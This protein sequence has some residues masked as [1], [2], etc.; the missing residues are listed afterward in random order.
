MYFILIYLTTPLSMRMQF[1]EKKIIHFIKAQYQQKGTLFEK[2]KKKNAEHRIEWDGI[3]V[4]RHRKYL[5]HLK[6]I[7]K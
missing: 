5:F 7:Y 2:S 4:E 6:D 1:K 3:K